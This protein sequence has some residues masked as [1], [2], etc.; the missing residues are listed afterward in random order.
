M[1][2]TSI[3]N[4][5]IK[6]F[7]KLQQAKVRHQQGQLLL[8]GTHLLEE[9]CRAGLGFDVLCYS[10]D[11]QDNHSGLLSRAIA[12]SQRSEL[13]SD[14]V[15]AAIATTVNPDGVVAIAPYQLS[16]AVAWDEHFANTPFL[17][18][19]VDALQDPGNLGTIIRT[20]TAVEVDMLVLSRNSVDPTQPKVLRASAG[21]WFHL[22]MRN[23]EHLPTTMAQLRQYFRAVPLQVIATS[24]NT[25]LSYWDIDYCQPSLIL[26]GNEGAGVS[27]EVL[28]S[29]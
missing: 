22:A 28:A 17:G 23:S 16:S 21:Q 18:V 9:A 3:R 8:E 10:L 29:A 25:H 12:Q 27:D 6:R 26:V 5:V 19:A 14:A 1:V 2:L 24:P 15:L 20:A 7:R 13:V 11:W 4:P